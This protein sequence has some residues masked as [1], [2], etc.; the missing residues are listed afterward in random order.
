MVNKILI[1]DDNPGDR[2]L[3]KE[4]INKAQLNCDIKEADTGEEGI[5]LLEEQ[6]VD[7]VILDTKLPGIDGFETCQKIKENRGIKTKVIILTGVVDAINV[8]RA[9]NVGADDY[10]VKTSN[11]EPLLD[12]IKN[13][14]V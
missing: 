11:W 1:V 8:R 3:I 6:K 5:K 13:I 2:L 12:C 14:K 4:A 7:V 10:T 9:R